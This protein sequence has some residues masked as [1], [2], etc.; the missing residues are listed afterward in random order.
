MAID[1]VSVGVSDMTRAKR[2]YDAM[3]APLGLAPIFPVEINGTL[4]GVGYGQ[5]QKPS[6]WIQFPINHQPS[7]AGNGVHVA[8]TAPTRE[9]VDGFY[10]AALANGAVE[11]GAPGLRTEYHPGYY[12]AFVRDHDG[13]KLEA[14][15][16]GF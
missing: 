10:L 6:F 11:D 9:A 14:V 2:L 7:T 16:H 13:N 3:L 15:N 8:F 4:V 1:H 5:G 12:G